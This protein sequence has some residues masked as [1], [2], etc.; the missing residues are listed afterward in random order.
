MDNQNQQPNQQPQYQQQPPY[1]Q[2]QQPYQQYQQPYQQYY[3][4]NYAQGQRPMKP[5]NYLVW[6]ILCTILCC[7]PLG[8]VSIVYASKV[9]N[10]YAAGDYFGAQ[11]ASNKAKNFAMWGAIIA[12]VGIILY[13]LIIVLI[14]MMG[15]M[16]GY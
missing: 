10:L 1:Q 3:Q 8:I 12:V 5:D 14:G 9:D 7:L 6:A 2:P 11:D 16:A 13:I 15:S 4:P